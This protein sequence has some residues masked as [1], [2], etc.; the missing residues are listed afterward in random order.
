M[1]AQAAAIARWAH[2]SPAEI[3]GRPATA[4]KL[5]SREIKNP[6]AD[7]ATVVEAVTQNAPE[8]VGMVEAAEGTAGAAEGT[9]A[10][11][12]KVDEEFQ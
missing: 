1:A 10:A 6:L 4:G 2:M 11:K 3:R 8:A 7:V 5:A 12:R 9:E